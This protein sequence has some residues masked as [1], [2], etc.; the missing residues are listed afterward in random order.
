VVLGAFT[1]TTEGFEA[2]MEVR[3]ADGDLE[4]KYQIMKQVEQPVE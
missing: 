1:S 4:A 2:M 3:Y